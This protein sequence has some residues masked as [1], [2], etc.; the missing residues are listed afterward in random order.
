MTGLQP[1]IPT[2]PSVYHQQALDPYNSYNSM[3]NSLVNAYTR[4]NTGISS[5]YPGLGQTAPRLNLYPDF[6]TADPERNFYNQK[7]PPMYPSSPL[8]VPTKPYD[9][10]SHLIHRY[11]RNDEIPGYM[12]NYPRTHS[13]PN[14]AYPGNVTDISRSQPAPS[15]GVKHGNNSIIDLTSPMSPD[16]FRSPSQRS[17]IQQER[18]HSR[19]SNQ[20]TRYMPKENG[21]HQL[22]G[23]SG[24][25]NRIGKS[26]SSDSPYRHSNL[27]P[28]SAPHGLL[29][30][31]PEPVNPS[32]NLLEDMRAFP[33]P[34][35]PPKPVMHS[36]WGIHNKHHNPSP[37][38]TSGL[39]L[40]KKSLS[41]SSH[42]PSKE[43][44]RGR[45]E[46][47]FNYPEASASRYDGKNTSSRGTPTKR[48]SH[49]DPYGQRIEHEKYSSPTLPPRNVP[50]NNS[51]ESALTPY[52]HY[53]LEAAREGKLPS[54]VLRNRKFDD[55][56]MIR[57]PHNVSKNRNPNIP[58]PKDDGNRSY[59]N[60]KKEFD[61]VRSSV[62]QPMMVST[63]D[64]SG[65]VIESNVSPVKED[66]EKTHQELDPVKSDLLVDTYRNDSMHVTPIA[67]HKFDPPAI[68]GDDMDT[69]RIPPG[70]VVVQANC[71]NATKFNRK[72]SATNGEDSCIVCF[73]K[74]MTP[75]WGGVKVSLLALIS[76]A[77]ILSL[78]HMYFI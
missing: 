30:Y 48:N 51:N 54:D 76:C 13:V 21:N 10:D 29:P 22:A 41:P 23:P 69:I 31:N 35:E 44:S 6:S 42:I 32:E 34:T 52:E 1:Y 2:G 66:V 7:Y 47:T 62:I 73:L 64:V 26:F 38:Q 3:L 58:S 8:P 56:R 18:N 12:N 70:D 72:I 24:C 55:P 65:A 25:E 9:M 45:S 75:A 40:G 71:A 50:W 59:E 53:V 27:L 33:K 67:V 5:A 63:E 39:E 61:D 11:Q 28:Y 16:N 57:I 49:V 74:F 68:V 4:P 46:I 60:D 77:R 19:S 36:P 17:D 43:P 20:D 14:K 15:N 78:F 37:R